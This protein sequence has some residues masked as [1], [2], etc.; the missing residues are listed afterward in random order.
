MIREIQ[1]PDLRAIALQ[2]LFA[3]AQKPKSASEGAKESQGIAAF[4]QKPAFY[5][6]LV[7]RVL[8]DD[9]FKGYDEKKLHA[10]KERITHEQYL[11]IEEI[12][13]GFSGLQNPRDYRFLGRV[14][15]FIKQDLLTQ[16]ASLMAGPYYVI[17]L[18]P[19]WNTEFNNNQEI[20]V[21]NLRVEEGVVKATIHH[22]VLKS[23]VAPYM[24]M[25]TAALGYWEAIG[26]LWNVRKFGK[27]KL[28]HIQIPIEDIIR[29]EYA[30]LNLECEEKDDGS[31]WVNGEKKAERIRNTGN[32]ETDF[33][34][35]PNHKFMA[36]ECDN[37]R[38]V[39]VIGDVYDDKGDP[40]LL[41]GE[42]YGAPCFVYEVEVPR[43]SWYQR[44]IF[45][46]NEFFRGAGHAV[47]KM[48]SGEQREGFE[49]MLTGS[50]EV[51]FLQALED[52]QRAEHEKLK[53]NLR[54][55]RL[56]AELSAYQKEHLETVLLLERLLKEDAGARH[57]RKNARQR[58]MGVTR[59]I[60]HDAVER[61]EKYSQRYE[62]LMAELLVSEFA[63]E[64]LLDEV[65]E[66]EEA[67]EKLREAAQHTKQ[68]MDDLGLLKEQVKQG[69]GKKINIIYE[70]INEVIQRVIRGV[71]LT[72][73]DVE[74][75]FTESELPV[76]YD[77][78]ILF[79]VLVNSINNAAEAC[80]MDAQDTRRKITVHVKPADDPAKQYKEIII[81]Q[82]GYMGKEKERML[83]ERRRIVSDKEGLKQFHS[84]HTI[85]VK[86]A[87]R[88]LEDYL[89]GE[90]AF[91]SLEREGALTKIKLYD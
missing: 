46:I 56:E 40:V 83:N 75:E 3:H 86:D 11:K 50:R 42:I 70:P 16:V 64:T 72:Y 58:I 69:E 81:E 80:L 76:R 85:G 90:Y 47:K 26:G 48:L 88:L 27:T 35:T 41:E 33:G 62:E 54:A 23:R 45:A 59:R 32:P 44:T 30:Y 18:S 57:D 24:T 74:F 25:V 51:M 28:T 7:R 60:W 31:I 55:A 87:A 6:E 63:L 79:G 49:I 84:G 21:H 61:E 5:D 8:A 53:T 29:R 73:P 68:I 65:L 43:V 2:L 78:T 39:R 1:E 4:C 9:L 10:T 82:T 91:K 71:K 37:I 20:E 34:F 12:F 66:D 77:P 22:Y 19:K 38:G 52:V 15:P 89:A 67:P 13:K 36:Q 14:V 17:D